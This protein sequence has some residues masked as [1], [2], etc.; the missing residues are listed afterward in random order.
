MSNSPFAHAAVDSASSSN[1]RGELVAG[2]DEKTAKFLEE[3]PAASGLNIPPELWTGF[4]VGV[5]NIESLPQTPE[6]LKDECFRVTADLVI[7][8]EAMVDA[9]VM[10]EDYSHL[11][12]ALKAKI[13]Q[14]EEGTDR[15][16]VVPLVRT[17][18]LI[19]RG[20]EDMPSL[21]GVVGQWWLTALRK[22]KALQFEAPRADAGDRTARLECRATSQMDRIVQRR[23]REEARQD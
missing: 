11:A 7:T 17:R 2:L 22:H 20:P 9:Y 19:I 3:C 13:K 6:A 14:L 18:S 10:I 15:G 4:A 1:R 5:A 21:G 12:R 8:R 23:G 16:I